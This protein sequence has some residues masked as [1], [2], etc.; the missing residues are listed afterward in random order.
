MEWGRIQT[1]R[2]LS[3]QP[4][5]WAVALCALIVALLIGI[6][7]RGLLAALRQPATLIATAAATAPAEDYAGRISNANL[8]GVAPP[9]AG[10]QSLPSTQLQLTLRGV[11]TADDP[12]LASA[13]IENSDGKMQIVKTGASVGADATLRQVYANRVVIE[14][15]GLQENLYFPTNASPEFAA[16]A[17]PAPGLSAPTDSLSEDERKANIIRRLEELRARGSLSR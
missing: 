11:F 17:E 10:D 4:E 15:S 5:R 9:A 1:W 7:A 3:E 14:R 2:D 16:A 13:I 12:A 8:F 6:E